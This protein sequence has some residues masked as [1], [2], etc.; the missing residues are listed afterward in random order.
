MVPTVGAKEIPKDPATDQ[1]SMF[2]KLQE[3]TQ[4]QVHEPKETC[5]PQLEGATKFARWQNR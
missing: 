1:C 3:E 4:V 2:E 5:V